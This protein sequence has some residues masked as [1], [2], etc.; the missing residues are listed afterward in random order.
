MK[1]QNLKEA[2]TKDNPWIESGVNG[3]AI[4]PPN[5]Y[6]NVWFYPDEGNPYRICLGEGEFEWK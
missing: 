1:E 2:I 3:K 6:G 5:S 4:Y